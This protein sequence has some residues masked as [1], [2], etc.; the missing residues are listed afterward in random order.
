[1]VAAPVSK[2]VL[3]QTSLPYA[4]LATPFAAPENGEDEVPIVNMS[5]FDPTPEGET[6]SPPR[7]S[8]CRGYINVNVVFTEGGYKWTCNLCSMSNPVPTW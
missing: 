6:Q 4:M 8:R 5:T 3:V 1:M 7:C 2:D